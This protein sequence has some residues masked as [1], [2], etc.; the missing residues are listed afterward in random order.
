MYLQ[1]HKCEA[2]SLCCNDIDRSTYP[3][4]AVH[5]DNITRVCSLIMYG[6]E[7]KDVLHMTTL[8]FST[9]LRVTGSSSSTCLRSPQ[10]GASSSAPNLAYFFF[11]SRVRK[12][13][14]LLS[15]PDRV[16]VDNNMAY[17]GWLKSVTWYE[18]HEGCFVFAVAVFDGQLVLPL[19]GSLHFGDDQT[20]H[21]VVVAVADE[22]VA[23][24]LLNQQ[25][26][27]RVQLACW[28]TSIVLSEYTYQSA[29]M[30]KLR[31]QT[32][33][34][35]RTWKLTQCLDASLVASSSSDISDMSFSLTAEQVRTARN[36]FNFDS[37]VPCT[38]VQMRMNNALTLL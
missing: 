23:T 33:R 28:L 25:G 16:V 4:R 17:C 27:L 5:S 31:K 18:E 26:S 3:V 34:G 9:F 6:I 10:S 35:N 19:V 11:F 36:G 14:P 7:P 32:R 24:A 29:V 8:T 30:R 20:Y 1:T 22:L 38:N 21:V 15:K 2:R 13:M 37:H 12:S